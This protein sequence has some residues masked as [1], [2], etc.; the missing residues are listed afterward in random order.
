MKDEPETVEFIKVVPIVDCKGKPIREGSVL[1]EINDG[2]RGVVGRIIRKGDYGTAFDAVGDIQIISSSIGVRVTNRYNQWQHIPKDEQTHEERYLSWLKT[3]LDYN[4][5]RLIY[6][7]GL[8][9]DQIKAIDGIMALLPSDIVSWENGPWPDSIEQALAFLK[10]YL[11]GITNDPA[12][13]N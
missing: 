1:R 9:D 12:R 10:D 13:T 6:G 4:G 7:E 3:P 5:A 8:T 2:E 11:I